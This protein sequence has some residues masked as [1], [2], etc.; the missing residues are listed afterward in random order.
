MPTFAGRC[1]KRVDTKCD[2]SNSPRNLKGNSCSN[3]TPASNR[4]FRSKDTEF[5]FCLKQRFFSVSTEESQ[6]GA[7]AKK[8]PPRQGSLEK[9][10]VCASSTQSQIRR[11]E[12]TICRRISNFK[13][14]ARLKWKIFSYSDM[15]FGS[16]LKIWGDLPDSSAFCEV[17]P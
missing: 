6:C 11:S 1:E 7:C 16:R 13:A 14:A 4:V 8:W 2:N 15:L 12:S 3:A 9:A 17:L 5:Q 10:R